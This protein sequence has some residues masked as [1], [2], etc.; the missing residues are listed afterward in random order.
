LRCVTTAAFGVSCQR[1]HILLYWLWLTA[2]AAM[3]GRSWTCK[4]RA[5]RGLDAWL[6]SSPA[7]VLQL[8]KRQRACARYSPLSLVCESLTQV[9]DLGA[10]RSINTVIFC[11]WSCAAANDGMRD[12]L[13]E[14]PPR[15]SQCSKHGSDLG[16]NV[17]AVT[18]L[19]DHASEASNLPSMRLRLFSTVDAG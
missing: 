14:F 17:D 8:T 1:I 15:P 19:L 7:R 3:M 6:R 2:F 4:S 16:D 18:I 10:Q 5:A 11:R 12:A 13:G 9:N